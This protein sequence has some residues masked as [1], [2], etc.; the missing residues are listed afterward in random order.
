MRASARRRPRPLSHPRRPWSAADAAVAAALVALFVERLWHG[1]HATTFLYDTLSYHLH[2]P[3][4]WM[5]EARLTIV[6]AVFGDTSPAYAPANLELWFLLLMA[7]LRSFFHALCRDLYFR[8][9]KAGTQRA[10]DRA[11]AQHALFARS[12]AWSSSLA[13]GGDCRRSLF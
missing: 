6:P 12:T 10:H 7:P 9:G 2:M 1:L 13:R 8:S 4:T 5:H 3:A 11:C